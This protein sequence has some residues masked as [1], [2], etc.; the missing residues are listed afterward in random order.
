MPLK[1]YDK[2]DKDS[3]LSMG[4]GKDPFTVTLNGVTGGCVYKK[5]YIRNEDTAKWYSDISIRAVDSN[6]LLTYVDGSN[7]FEWRLIDGDVRPLLLTWDRTEPG[8]TLSFSGLVLGSS[9]LADISTYVP[10]WV[11]VDIERGQRIS[12]LTNV[13]LRIYAT[14]GYVDGE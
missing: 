6:G 5:L 12:N 3:Y 14:E 7:G 13:V 10:F 11:K 1:I 2:P 8:N 4:T 9:T